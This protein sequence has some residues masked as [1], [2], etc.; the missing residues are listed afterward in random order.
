MCHIDTFC[1]LHCLRS[2]RMCARHL[3]GSS[4]SGKVWVRWF[5]PL[6]HHF[7]RSEVILPHQAA[8]L[9][10]KE[11]GHNHSFCPGP[12]EYQFAFVHPRVTW[13]AEVPETGMQQK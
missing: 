9:L 1:V 4:N 11:E 5:A 8:V 10:D 3:Q 2:G 6:V 13:R 7:E 12:L